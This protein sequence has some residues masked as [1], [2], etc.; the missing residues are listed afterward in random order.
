MRFPTSRLFVLLA[1][2]L[3]ATL[4]VSATTAAAPMTAA[5]EPAAIGNV[6]VKA[7][8]EPGSHE[9]FEV[10]LTFALICPGG[11]TAVAV[12]VSFTDASGETT[13][14]LSRPCN[15]EWANNATTPPDVLSEWSVMAFP[16]F[17]PILAGEAGM[18]PYVL[19][20]PP[21]DARGPHPFLYQVTGPG[22]V[23][24]QAPITATTTPEQRV[25]EGSAAFQ[26]DCAARGEVKREADGTG[27]CV[28]AATTRYAA[29][30][31]VAPPPSATVVLL[32]ANSRATARVPRVKPSRCDTLGPR[33][34]FAQ[35]SNLVNL[36]WTG[37]G[38]A[39]ATATGTETGYHRPLAHLRA[40]VR[41]YRLR[42][43]SESEQ[44]YTRL[45]VH[46]R[47][48][49]RTVRFPECPTG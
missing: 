20:T 5:D 4:F 32:C 27:Y 48:G 45:R 21:P 3:A 1:P 39:E 49:T 9:A 10:E 18:A 31:P 8:T 14:R 47:Y 17:A 40:T 13:E 16:G 23:V 37:W 19:F 12:S 26:G 44:R 7:G 38:R 11:R 6:G 15:G 24:A 36:H 41:A 29:G 43:C 22:G 33:Q 42:Q 35:G 46:D 25:T 2:V 28:V 34:S 30:W